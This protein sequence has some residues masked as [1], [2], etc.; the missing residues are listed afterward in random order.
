[1]ADT[2]D[3]TTEEFLPVPPFVE[4]NPTK[5]IIGTFPPATV[6]WDYPFFFPNRQNRLWNT[7]ARVARDDVGYALPTLLD[8][9]AEVEARKAILRQLG[10]AMVNII[11]RCLRKN[12]SALDNDLEVLEMEDIVNHYLRPN[13]AIESIFLTSISGRNSCL[14]LLRR[15]LR[16]SGIPV[17]PYKRSDTSRECK[18]ADPRE[19]GFR[20]EDRD[21]SVYALFSPSPTAMR[22]GITEQVLWEQ[23]RV[24]QSPKP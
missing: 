10:A 24:L 12:G 23:Y 13:P 4:G 21:I 17:H 1:M 16:E 20:L 7:L 11:R 19:F 9:N 6:R 18:I 3:T 2:P 5:L 15:H 8:A 14:S 22:S